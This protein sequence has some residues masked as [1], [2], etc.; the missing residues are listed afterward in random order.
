[1]GVDSVIA[2]NVIPTPA[3]LRCRLEFEREQAAARLHQF[4]LGSRLIRRAAERLAANN[5]FDVIHRTMVG[6]Q[7]RLAEHSCRR[8]DVVVR[9][10]SL[11]ARWH[12]FHRPGKYIALGRKA[13]EEHIDEIK[14]LLVRR[15]TAH[16]HPVANNTLAVAA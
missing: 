16:E 2:V 6:A 1:M 3:Y 10:L 4:G 15:R 14:A 5:V 13:A 12:D 11:E 9:P 7:M 8:A